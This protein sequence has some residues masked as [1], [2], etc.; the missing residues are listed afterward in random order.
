MENYFISKGV[1]SQA[2][3]VNFD[4]SKSNNTY[5]NNNLVRPISTSI[6]YFIKY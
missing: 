1:D 2:R 4:A 6:K 3:D 5:K